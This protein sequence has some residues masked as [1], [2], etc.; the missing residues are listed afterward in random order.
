[1]SES[2]ISISSIEVEIEQNQSFDT[3]LTYFMITAWIFLVIEVYYVI[4]VMKIALMRQLL[5]Q[6]TEQDI[7]IDRKVC[8]K[9]AK[10]E[11]KWG[12]NRNTTGI[13]II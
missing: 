4:W 12:K 6:D 7:E 9:L 2:T 13:F 1:M 3:V 11:K 5:E 8:Q 10:S